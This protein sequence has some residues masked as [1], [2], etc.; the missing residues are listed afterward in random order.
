MPSVELWG[1]LGLT[2]P[3]RTVFVT[4]ALMLSIVQTGLFLSHAKFARHQ[5]DTRACWYDDKY[6]KVDFWSQR[7]VLL[8]SH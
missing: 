3:E 5:W 4:I 1:Y 8:A 6:A 2:E 7:V